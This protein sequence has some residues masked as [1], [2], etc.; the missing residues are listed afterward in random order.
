[1][2]IDAHDKTV[3]RPNEQSTMTTLNLGRP[4]VAMPSIQEDEG[5][6]CGTSC[7]SSRR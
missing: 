6:G 1:V 2:C 3:V 7:K 5:Q 4:T